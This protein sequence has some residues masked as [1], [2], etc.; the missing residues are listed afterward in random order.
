MNKTDLVGVALLIAGCFFLFAYKLGLEIALPLLSLAPFIESRYAIPLSIEL[1][2]YSP[3]RAY[4]LC[5]SLNLLVIPAVYGFMDLLFPP[6]R[7]KI[8]FIG[9]LV[10]YASQ[11]ASKRNWTFPALVAFI[12]VPLPVTGAY[13]GTLIAYL[14]DLDRKKSAAAIALGVYAAGLITLGA[15][16]GLKVLT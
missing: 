1:G 11:K 4:L 12:A 6:L 15:V 3:F 13:T 7:G 10:D 8:E 5:T 16:T 9:K 2:G 14:L